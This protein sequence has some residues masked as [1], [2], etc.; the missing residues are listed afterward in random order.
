MKVAFALLLLL[1]ILQGF[2]QCRMTMNYDLLG[3]FVKAQREGKHVG[4]YSASVK[5]EDSA[6]YVGPQHGLKEADKI[7]MLP[8]QPNGVNIDQ[9]SGYV[10]VDAKAERAL[11]YYF[12]ESQNSSTKPLVLW[13]NGGINFNLFHS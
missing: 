1:S 2:V 3:E 11:F 9:Y 7:E 10:T 8:G 6:V 4:Y 13:L 5:A 12:V